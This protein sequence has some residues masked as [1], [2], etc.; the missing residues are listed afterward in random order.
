MGLIKR[1]LDTYTGIYDF[2]TDGGAVGALNLQV[3]IPINATVM[4]FG[5]QSVIPPA[6]GGAA[7]LSFDYIQTNTLPFATSVG[8]FLAATAITSWAA[9]GNVV[10]G[11]S[12]DGAVQVPT[13]LLIASVSV[14]MSIGTAALTAGRLIFF[15]RCV[16]FDFS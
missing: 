3:P 4:E 10:M 12:P 11:I 8:F 5:V 2:A 6:S 7:T 16:L 14:G 1:T 9:R 13:S 15:C